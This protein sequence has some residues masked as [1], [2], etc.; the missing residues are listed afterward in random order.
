MVQRVLAAKQADIEL[1]LA[2]ARE[3][4]AFVEKIS[5]VLDKAVMQ[6][7]VRMDG[8]FGVCFCVDA[9]AVEIRLRRNS[10]AET[11]RRYADVQYEAGDKLYVSCTAEDG[12]GC[13]IV[14]GDLPQ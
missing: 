10:V 2:R 1:G 12:I 6:Y 3:Q 8:R 7:S 5:R 14:F 4:K 13:G 11:L 9:E